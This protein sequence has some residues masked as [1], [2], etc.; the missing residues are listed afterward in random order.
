MI[1]CWRR[2]QTTLTSAFHSNGSSRSRTFNLN[3]SHSVVKQRMPS[4]F[5][6]NRTFFLKII[7]SGYEGQRLLFGKNPEK[8]PP[9]WWITIPIVYK[10]IEV[11]MREGSIWIPSLNAYTKDN[12]PVTVSGSLFYKIYDSNKAC[13]AVQDYLQS[14]TYLGTSAA[15]SVI[16]KYEYD[17]INGDRNQI[18]ESLKQNIHS[19]CDSWGMLCTRFEI[20]E[21]RP[22]NEHVMRQL[23]LQMEAERKRRENDL[24]T[25]ASVRTAEGMRDAE[26]LKSEGL[27]AAAK[28]GAEAAFVQTQREADGHKYKIMAE[29][30]GKANEIERIAKAFGGDHNLAFQFLTEM[31]RIDQLKAI[32][33]KSQNSTYFLPSGLENIIKKFIPKE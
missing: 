22:Q 1:S 14:M 11:D 26:I 29:A 5:Q 16:G 27:L 7:E 33:T 32:A 9:G 8:L 21:F 24:N 6:T 31:N 3:N 30:E 19:Q 17:E 12:V 20:Q 2:S 15:R 13:F 4:N 28:N 10:I 18:N 25:R 23:E